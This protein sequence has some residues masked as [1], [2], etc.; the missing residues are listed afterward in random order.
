MA[1]HDHQQGLALLGERG[2]WSW[3]HLGNYGLGGRIIQQ[4]EGRAV[5]F[6]RLSW[7]NRALRTLLSTLRR[8]A[9]VAKHVG[10]RDGETGQ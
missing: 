4:D 5:S 2:A 6:F 10:Q 7:G 3:R 9:A 8:A 1:V